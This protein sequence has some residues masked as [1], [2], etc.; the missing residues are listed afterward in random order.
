MLL[1]DVEAGGH[2]ADQGLDRLARGSERQLRP[3]AERPAQLNT[4]LRLLD[5]EG[6]AAVGADADAEP[7]AAEFEDL[8]LARVRS[9]LELHPREPAVGEL[10]RRGQG[11]AFHFRFH[12]FIFLPLRSL[13]TIAGLPRG[14]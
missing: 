10:V 5:S 13:A 9:G 6:L 14:F 4:V 12:S 3:Y 11:Q 2:P 1:I 7:R 8:A